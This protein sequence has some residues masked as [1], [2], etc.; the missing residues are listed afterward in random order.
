M[1]F[2]KPKGLDRQAAA[3]LVKT[4]R[5]FV[6]SRVRMMNSMRSLLSELGLVVPQGRKALLDAIDNLADDPG[7]IPEEALFGIFASRE[8][9]ARLDDKIDAPSFGCARKPWPPGMPCGSGR[10]PASGRPTQR[11]SLPALRK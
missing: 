9:I 2:A 7:E 4:Q 11:R 5:N 10:F 6:K 8:M 1:R 3:I